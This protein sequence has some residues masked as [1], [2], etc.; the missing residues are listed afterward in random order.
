MTVVEARSNDTGEY[1]TLLQINGRTATGTVSVAG[2]LF[3]ERLPRLVRIDDFEIEA[4]LEGHLLLTEHQ[5]RPGVVAGL[6]NV[7][8]SAGV[9]ITRMH[10]GPVGNQKLAVAVIGLDRPLPP[11][12]V[13]AIM[14]LGTVFTVHQLAL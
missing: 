11:E 9:N 3:D 14:G 4:I 6:S 8:A 7:I 13:D 2:T 5:D 12:S 1:R 10:L